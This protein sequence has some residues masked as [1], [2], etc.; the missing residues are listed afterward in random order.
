MGCSVKEGLF[1][2]D[3]SG[4][5]RGTT[6]AYRNL[7]MITAG[8]VKYRNIQAVAYELHAVM[9]LLQSLKRNLYP[10]FLSCIYRS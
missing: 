10:S 6:P 7:V 3:F 8:Q 2:V 5:E 4:V 1:S 9:L